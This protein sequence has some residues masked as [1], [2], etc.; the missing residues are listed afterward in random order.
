MRNPEFERAVEL[1]EA[2]HNST[3]IEV[4]GEKWRVVGVAASTHY[5]SVE[6]GELVQGSISH[7]ISLCGDPDLD[8]REALA[9]LNGDGSLVILDIMHY[10]HKR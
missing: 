8:A 7:D 3:P 10:R 4:D 2:L 6:T 5:V 1:L 9:T